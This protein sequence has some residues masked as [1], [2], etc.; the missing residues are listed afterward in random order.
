M[1]VGEYSSVVLPIQRGRYGPSD[2]SKMHLASYR[3]ICDNTFSIFSWMLP[4]VSCKTECL[5]SISA[6]LD[7]V[8]RFRTKKTD[9]ESNKTFQK[10][11]LSCQSPHRAGRWDYLVRNVGLGFPLRVFVNIS[12]VS[13]LFATGELGT[14]AWLSFHGWVS[15]WYERNSSYQVLFNF[16]I[17]TWSSRSRKWPKSYVQND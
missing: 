3:N 16:C 15:T 4:V 10:N 2:A 13:Q 14:N 12:Y 9:S 8:W 6:A 11:G 7:T 17:W 1:V 5:V